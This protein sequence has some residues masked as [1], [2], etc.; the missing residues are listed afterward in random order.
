MAVETTIKVVADVIENFYYKG[1][2]NADRDLR[3]RDFLQYAKFAFGGLLRDMYYKLK[4]LE[5]GDEYFFISQ[6]LERQNFKVTTDKQNRKRVDLS[7]ANF[8]RLPRNRHIFEVI[9]IGENDCYCEDF[10][11]V[12]PGEERWYKGVEYIGNPFF[13]VFG[14]GFDLYHVD[15]CVTEVEVTG[16]YDKDDMI[17]TTDLAFDILNAVLGD[18]LKVKGWPVDVTNGNDSNVKEAQSALLNQAAQTR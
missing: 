14:K 6:N 5:E 3:T 1:I 13:V 18:A 2:V 9:P 4:D 10:I 7:S 11:Q 17:V 16:F 8:I 12:Q 15:D